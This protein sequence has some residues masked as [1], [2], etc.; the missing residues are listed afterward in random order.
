MKGLLAKARRLYE[1]DRHREALPIAMEVLKLAPR[2]QSALFYAAHGLY[3]AGL[4]RRSLQYWKRLKAIAPEELNIRLNMGACYEELGDNIAA[5]K[6]YKQEL[7]LNHVCGQAFFNIGLLYYR[8]HKYRLATP[9]LERCFAQKHC[10][11]SVVCPLAKC[12][13]KTGQPDKEQL[14]YEEY[15]LLKPD[16]AWALNNLGSHLMDQGAYH[17]ALLKFRKAARIDPDDK[18]IARNI[19]KTERVLRGLAPSSKRVMA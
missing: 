2:N 10:V 6:H 12:Y 17:R 7:I 19:R 18:I 14:L 9:Y 5:I 4:F 16:D 15:L 8:K 11:D 1:Q 3:F 13:Y